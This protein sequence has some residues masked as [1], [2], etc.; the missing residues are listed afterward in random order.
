MTCV[1]HY[2]QGYRHDLDPNY[3][4]KLFVQEQYPHQNQDI[5]FFLNFIVLEALTSPLSSLASIL[6]LPYG[7]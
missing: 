5:E 3:S 6:Y 2:M 4:H 7:N 1:L